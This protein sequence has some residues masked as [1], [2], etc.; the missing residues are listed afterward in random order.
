MAILPCSNY[1]KLF[2]FFPLHYFLQR[3]P[4]NDWI[5]IHSA[6]LAMLS[7]KSLQLLDKPII[8]TN[9][10]SCLL[11]QLIRLVKGQTQFFH[12]ICKYHSC[13]P[14]HSLPTM[15]V[16]CAFGIYSIFD[17]SDWLEEKL[18]DVLWRSVSNRQH[19]ILKVGRKWRRH[20]VENLKNMSYAV[21]FETLEVGSWLNAAKVEMVDY[22]ANGCWH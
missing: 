4:R 1:L 21:A 9:H 16:N 3:L 2:V 12:E 5:N 19:F 14:R 15:D 22:F 7:F 6:P 18:W 8:W 20:A 17:V 11:D 13:A 10:R